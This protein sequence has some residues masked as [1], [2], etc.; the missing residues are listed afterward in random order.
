LNQRA[1][2]VVT[3]TPVAKKEE[4]VGKDRDTAAGF[5]LFLHSDRT[6]KV[7]KSRHQDSLC[8]TCLSASACAIRFNTTVSIRECRY[9]EP[10]VMQPSAGSIAPKTIKKEAGRQVILGLCADCLRR[11][12]CTVPKPESGIWRCVHYS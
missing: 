6:W 2:S 5:L 3:G 1:I 9:Y 11:P 10:N 8:T 4:G 7:K 12:E